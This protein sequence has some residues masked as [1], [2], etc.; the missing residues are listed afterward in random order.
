[1]NLREE[2]AFYALIGSAEMLLNAT[3]EEGA[4]SAANALRSSLIMANNVIASTATME[5]PENKYAEAIEAG[6][7]A[8]QDTEGDLTAAIIAALQFHASNSLNQSQTGE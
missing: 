8:Y 5:E 3:T 2:E 4:K 1:M 7:K 6:E